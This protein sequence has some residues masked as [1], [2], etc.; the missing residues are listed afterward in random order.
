MGT[1]A[2]AIIAWGPATFMRIYGWD[3][4][5]IGFGFGSVILI[6]GVS[7]SLLAGSVENFFSK[8]GYEDAKIRGIVTCGF[9]MSP[10]SFIGPMLV[11]LLTDFVFQ[12]DAALLYSL[13]I[14]VGTIGPLG[15]IL[16]YIN[17]DRYVEADRLSRQ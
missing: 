1:A 6:G 10:I 2:S 11:P 14:V 5:Q 16:L 17:R 12:D 4:Q 3:F 15:G 8:R 13:A 7:G 9:I